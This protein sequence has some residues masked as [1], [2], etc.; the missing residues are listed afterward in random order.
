LDC[1]AER[2]LPHHAAQ[3]RQPI[4]NKASI[5]TA[6]IERTAAHRFNGDTDAGF[7]SDANA[8]IAKPRLP[9]PACRAAHDIHRLQLGSSP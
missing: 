3:V 5:E 1:C 2:H 7:T 4:N 6:G 9:S 8:K